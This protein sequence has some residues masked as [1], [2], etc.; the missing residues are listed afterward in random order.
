V[1]ESYIALWAGRIPAAALQ[2]AAHHGVGIVAV[3]ADRLDVA[4]P[5][6]RWIPDRGVRQR[7]IDSIGREE[8]LG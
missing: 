7:M 8:G 3:S 4:V 5:A 1:D 6:R 2:A